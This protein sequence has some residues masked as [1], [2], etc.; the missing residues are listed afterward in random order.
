[1]REC[2]GVIVK[3]KKKILLVASSKGNKWIV[4]KGGIGK[5]RPRIAA[6]KELFEEAGVIGDLEEKVGIV[7]SK[8]QRIH[9][10]VMRRGLVLK[11]YPEQRDRQ[12]V[13]I[14]EAKNLLPSEYKKILSR[15]V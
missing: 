13:K 12:W 10:F 5:L 4:P 3:N 6:I 1:M 15:L 14:K 2:A 7:E 11:Q 8:K 9:L